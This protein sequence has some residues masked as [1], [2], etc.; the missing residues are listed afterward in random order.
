MQR[1]PSRKNSQEKKKADKELKK[2]FKLSSLLHKNKQQTEEKT[3][4]ICDA[5]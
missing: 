5:L 4:K 2:L 3:L 1:Y